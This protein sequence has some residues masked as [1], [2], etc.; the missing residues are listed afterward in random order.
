MAAACLAG[1]QGAFHLPTW[2]HNA[3]QVPSSC[4]QGPDRQLE[5]T[6]RPRHVAALTPDAKLDEP[7]DVESAVRVLVVLLVFLFVGCADGQLGSSNGQPDAGDDP[8]SSTT[9]DTGRNNGTPD[10]PAD[11]PVVMESFDVVVFGA[12]TGGSAAAIQAARMGANVALVEETDWVGGQMTAGGVSTMDEGGFNNDA[13]LYREFIAAAEAHYAALGKRARRCGIR[14]IP[15]TEP[16]VSQQLLREMLSDAGVTLFER[17]TPVAAR[18]DASKLQQV[19]AYQRDPER[20][21][22]FTAE[23]F[24][25]ATEYGDLLPVAGVEY[26]LGKSVSGSLDAAECVQDITV[27]PIIRRYDAVPVELTFS[28][29]PPGY[30]PT[31][32]QK[33]SEIVVAQGGFDW[34]ADGWNAGYP[35]DWKTHVSYRA[36]PDSAATEDSIIGDF[37]TITRT[38]VNWAND[39]PYTVDDIENRRFEA[40]CEAKL[41][42]LQ[43][44]YYVQNVM[45]IPNWA[46]ANDE[47]Y[48]SPYNLAQND[49]PEI[50]AEFAPIE[51]HLNPIPYVRE[52]RRMVGVYTLKGADIQRPGG[53]EPADT[54][55][56]SSIAVGDYAMDL[57]SCDGA[58]DLE[59][60]LET[61]SDLPAGF[62]GGPFQIPMEVLIARDVDGLLAAEK[63]ISQSR[64]V[65][66]AT[67]LQPSTMA[68]GQAAGALAALAAQRDEAARDVHPALVQ[69][70]LVEAGARLGVTKF[71]DV[72][73]TGSAWPSIEFVSGRG[74]LIGNTD[75]SFGTTEPLSRAQAA[76]YL[77]R[78]F[79]LDMSNPPAT[80]SFTDVPT[81][82]F[83][84]A[85]VEAV[86]AAGITSGCGDGTTFCPM[87][88]VTRGQAATFLARG[89]GFSGNA[90][91]GP[92][93][94]DVEPTGAHYDNIEY[95][96]SIGV[97]AGCR[98]DAYCPADALTRSQAAVLA[99]RLVVWDAEN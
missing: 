26:R 45:E 92:T 5:N 69:D 68:T 32:E 40:S 21:V 44:L 35:T 95:L 6:R 97:V 60:D 72:E 41:H 25:D 91:Q 79:E 7:I 87:D 37:D 13:G 78:L 34:E 61:A 27:A 59:S 96:Y 9:G 82:H 67:R 48:D 80:A 42:T 28:D 46:I 31:V 15:C 86:R 57:H 93:F 89:L 8:D 90:P 77:A 17:A 14:A 43:F 52:S 2:R 66:G 81:T 16:S 83:A 75:G 58:D 64:L 84:F 39:Y 71:T 4:G 55:F 30:G 29:P 3:P 85:A 99:H 73:Q 70:A 65:N 23:V 62:V 47:G 50:P 18:L 20:L 33:F 11:L 56:A 22:E 63:N 38:G 51:R 94:T 12:G 36:T 1:S 74:I 98:T 10:L 53:G 54:R 88:D 19:D 24:I 76:L 49:C